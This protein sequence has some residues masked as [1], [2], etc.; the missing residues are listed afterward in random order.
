MKILFLSVP[1]GQGHHQAAKA[2]LEYFQQD[3][4][5]ECRFLDVVDNTS[6]F[7]ADSLQKGYLI[8]TTVAPKMYGTFYDMADRRNYSKSSSLGKF[9]KSI[10]NKKLSKYIEIYDP[11]IIVTT[12][13]FSALA[14]TYL[15]KKQAIRAKTIAIITDFTIHPYWEDTKLDYYITASELLGFQAMKKG[16][17]PEKVKPFGIPIRPHFA[18]KLSKEEARKHLKLENRFTIL[19]M[20]GSMGY[21][22]DTLDTV[23]NLDRMEEDFQLVTVC[24]TNKRLKA[25]IDRMTKHKTIINYGYSNEVATLM[26]A[27]DC[28]I[29][30]PGG[31]ST[32]EALAKELPIIMMDPIPGQEDRNK[33]FM[34]NNGIA[35]SVS[36]TFPVTEAVYQLMHYD[37]KVESLRRNM[38][39]FSKPNA[40]A[41][42]GEFMLTLCQKPGKAAETQLKEA[43]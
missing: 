34:L 9:V 27:A 23:R 36:D 28:I 31:L 18:H 20:M 30:K 35:L 8:S 42:L 10:L 39:N 40:A 21:G 6:S 16:H 5:V 41:A 24:G 32:S 13:I 37:F 12:H 15:R 33:E 3:D 26:D 1:T 2:V 14:L 22:S 25:R 29:T 19:L 38:K 17:E 11:D 43:Q 4:S 7:L